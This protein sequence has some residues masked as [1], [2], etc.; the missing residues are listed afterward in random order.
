M[1]SPGLFDEIQVEIAPAAPPQPPSPVCVGCGTP[2][3]IVRV[4]GKNDRIPCCGES[5]CIALAGATS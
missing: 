3:R 5:A 1:T 4:L 2:T